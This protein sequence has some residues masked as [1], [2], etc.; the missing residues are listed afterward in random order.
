MNMKT[1]AYAAP[2]DLINKLARDLR[3]GG[4]TVT[5]ESETLKATVDIDGKVVVVVRA[6]R[7]RNN[8]WILRAVP[9]AVSA[10]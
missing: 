8:A 10:V 3:T 5:R 6:L 7:I 2:N 4:Y 9:E 1:L